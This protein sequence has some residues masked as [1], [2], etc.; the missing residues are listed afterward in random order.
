MKYGVFVYSALVISAFS[1]SAC[2]ISDRSVYEDGE[3]AVPEAFFST[4]KKNKTHK[5]WVT[6]NLGK[7]HFYLEGPNQEQ[8]YTYH[9]KQSY[10]RK[11]SLLFFLNYN[12]SDQQQ[13]N[14]HIIFCD[15]VVKKVWW[16]DFVNVQ[17]EK[18]VKYGGCQK[19]SEAISEKVEKESKD[20]EPSEQSS[21]NHFSYLE[22]FSA[23][24]FV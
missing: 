7:P 4:V 8:V 11:A 23:Y 5:R 18:V 19:D 6:D 13:K 17:I 22:L 14:Y 3:G 12:G 16:D 20:G 1:V 2:S 21:L 9:F 24:R 10:Y 15:D